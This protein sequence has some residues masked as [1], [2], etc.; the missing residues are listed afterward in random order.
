MTRTAGQSLATHLYNIYGIGESDIIAALPLR[1]RPA[2]YL[3]L[4]QPRGALRPGDVLTILERGGP[5]EGDAIIGLA[6]RDDDGS[7]Y[8]GCIEC[9]GG[10]EEADSGMCKPCRQDL[11]AQ[12]AAY[13]R[14]DFDQ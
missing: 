1:P 11:A 13:E 8:L 6:I 14:E 12:D 10:I 3:E 5:E 4:A 9:R 2:L 7:W